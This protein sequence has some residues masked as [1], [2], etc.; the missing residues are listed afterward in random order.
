MHTDLFEQPAAAEKASCAAAAAG[1]ALPGLIGEYRGLAGKQIGGRF[2]FQRLNLGTDAVAQRFEPDFRLGAP[3]LCDLVNLV[4]DYINIGHVDYFIGM[5]HCAEADRG[6]PA[7]QTDR[8]PRPHDPRSVAIAAS[9]AGS[10]RRNGVAATASTKNRLSSNGTIGPSRRAGVHS[11]S[12]RTS[13]RASTISLRL[14][15][16]TAR[17]DIESRPLRSSSRPISA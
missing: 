11:V 8:S 14:V 7:V 12:S 13:T 2:A 6:A 4:A 16:T 10:H 5:I 17:L 3:R 1:G 9:V 15:E